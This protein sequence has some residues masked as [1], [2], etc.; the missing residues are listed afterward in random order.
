MA[1]VTFESVAAAAETLQAAGQRASVRAVMAAIGG[2]SPNTVLKLL[3][4]WK[5]GRP[6]VRAADTE[7]DPKITAAIVEQMQRVAT[8]A[9]AAAEERAAGVDEDLQALSEAQAAAEQQINTLT[10]ERDAAQAQAAATDEQLQATQ[11]EAN[12]AAQQATTAAAALRQE[13]ATER[14]RQ[15]ATAAALARAEVRLEAVPGLQTE[16]DRLRAA[17]EADQQARQVAEQ[18]AAVLAAKLEAAER[19]ATEAEARTAKA[20]AATAQA[21]AKADATASELVKSNAAAQA[22]Q[23]RLESAARELDEVK[24]AMTTATIAAKKS[25]EE[26][27]ELRGQVDALKLQRV[28]PL[29]VKGNPKPK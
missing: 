26:A 20:D 2:G 16:I 6:V 29:V 15:E 10:T 25:G 17:L 3:G 24:K 5:A 11:A 13:L 21:T 4:E 12:R 22:L 28:A 1:I 19:R 18:S 7:L 27:A 14:T 9:A 23:G 8:A